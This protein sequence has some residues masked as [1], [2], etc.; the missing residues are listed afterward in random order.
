MSPE[1]LAVIFIIVVVIV[2]IFVVLWGL[3][4]APSGRADT[5]SN[6]LASAANANDSV[7]WGKHDDPGRVLRAG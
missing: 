6:L 7:V 4:G 3:F 2:A 5:F 1:R